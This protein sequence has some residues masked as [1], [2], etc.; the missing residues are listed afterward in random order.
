MVPTDCWE[1]NN[2]TFQKVYMATAKAT[3]NKYRIWARMFGTTPSW[4]DKNRQ[5][6]RMSK[7]LLKGENLISG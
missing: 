7:P 4:V 5:E 2:G 3:T 1:K 6:H